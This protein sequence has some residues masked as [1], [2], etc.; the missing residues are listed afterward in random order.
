MSLALNQEIA[1]LEEKLQSGS[2]VAMSKRLNVCYAQRDAELAAR[3]ATKAAAKAA[4]DAQMAKVAKKFLGAKAPSSDALATASGKTVACRDCKTDFLFSEKDQAFFT[5]QGFVEPVR[6]TSCRAAKKA[7]QRY[8]LTISCCACT[9]E[10]VHSI[11][12]QLHYEENGFEP[13]IRCVPC[14]AAKKAT[15]VAPV[16]IKCAK[17]ETDFTFS[18]ASQKH[19]KEQG[20]ASPMRCAPCRKVN[21]S[22]F[23]ASQAAATVA[24][25]SEP[26]RISTPP[27]VECISCGE[28]AVGPCCEGSPHPTA[29]KATENA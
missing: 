22:E 1:T 24:A 8:P 10:F 6:C 19:F 12:A 25:A 20:W 11:G 14:R 26:M 21:K 3:N 4:S 16:K 13:P 15:H 23:E 29:P 28:P 5:Q 27:L 7:K 18:V 17:C 2:N 9:N